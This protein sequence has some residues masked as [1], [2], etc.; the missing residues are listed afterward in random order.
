MTAKKQKVRVIA[1]FAARAR[2]IVRVRLLIGYRVSGFGDF[3]QP[4]ICRILD[5]L[6]MIETVPVCH[7]ITAVA[8][9][10]LVCPR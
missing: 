6:C 1:V 3:T 8:V 9:R 7:S 10:E 5:L 2:S 4:P